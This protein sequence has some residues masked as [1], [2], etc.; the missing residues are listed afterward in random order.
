MKIAVIGCG[1][2]GSIYAGLLA[3]GGHDVIA[4]D[5]GIEHVRVMSQTGLRVEGPLGDNIGKLR[6]V[7]SP[8]NDPMDLVVI[9]VKA[10]DVDGGATLAL[11][12]LGA[13]TVVLTIQNGIGSAETVANV[14]GAD[15]LA[16]GIASGF[17]ASRRGPG[18]VFHNAMQAIKFG[19]YSTLEKDRLEEV[20]NAWRQ[21]GFDAQ[22]VEDIEAMQWEKLICNT[23]YSAI[24]ALTGSNV[25]AVMADAALMKISSDAAT[26]AWKVA[27]ALGLNLSVDDP[28]SFA[29]AFGARMPGAR[30]SMLADHDAKRVSEIDVINGAVVRYG[31]RVNV[32]TPVNDMLVALVKAKESGSGPT[33]K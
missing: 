7:N 25:G 4:V 18:H 2:M 14:V 15:R 10:A 11:P 5:R 13:H 24:C 1:A 3:R 22:A 6:A 30:P 29:H 21:G 23:A 19:A 33:R 27:K 17:G 28:V 8:P 12:L 26:E 32:D 16:V 31:R 20:A 9:A